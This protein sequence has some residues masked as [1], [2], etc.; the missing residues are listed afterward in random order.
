MES[1]R[2]CLEEAQVEM[3]ARILRCPIGDN[4]EDCPLHEIRK[5]PVE[6]RLTWLHQKTDDEIIELYGYHVDCL[7]S[8]TQNQMPETD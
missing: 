8:K 5:R 4:P 7:E 1:R 3:H 2:I 6:D